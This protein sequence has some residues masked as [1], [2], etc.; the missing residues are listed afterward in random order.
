MLV[1]GKTL[2]R[3]RRLMTGPYLARN[4]AVVGAMAAGDIAGMLLPRRAAPLP[5]ERPL[6]ILV[7]NPAHLGDLIVTLPVLARLRAS[8]RVARLGL[9]IG[10]WSR[11]VLEL[12]DLAD[13]VYC[14][15]HWRLNRGGT[16]TAAKLLR[17]ART[18]AAA[19]AALRRANYDVAADTYAYFG[20]SADVL[21]SAGVPMRIGFASG[22]AGTLYTHRLAFDP[23]LSMAANQSRLLAPILGDAASADAAVD[24][25]PGFRPDPAAERLAGEL[26]D[27]VVFHVGP[28]LPHRDWPAVQWIALGRHLRADGLRL[29]FTGAASERAQ[30]GPIQEALGGEDLLGRLDLRGFA[31][32]LARARGLVSIDTMAGHL[33]ALFRTPNAVVF[34]G[35]VPPG[36][37]APNQPFARAVTEAVACAPCNR[38]FGCEAMTCLRRVSPEAVHAALRQAMAAKAAARETPP[39]AQAHLEAAP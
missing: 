22:G 35:V 1:N 10:S 4:P 12:G 17:H 25:L 27:F 15:D 34:P 20:N 39:L 14:V 8:G 31:T 30:V 23:G 3:P 29:A 2:P 9:A 37:W 32:L 38:T 33:A 11:P 19:L 13:E 24:P 21:W 28:G 26:G 16:G 7:T 36:L 5:A 18:R 6:R